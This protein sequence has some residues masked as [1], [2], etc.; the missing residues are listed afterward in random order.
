MPL[1]SF[2]NPLKTSENLCFQ[3]VKKE[4]SEMKWINSFMY[5]VE[6]W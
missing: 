1:F 3:E 6:N 4:T 5:S 2:Y